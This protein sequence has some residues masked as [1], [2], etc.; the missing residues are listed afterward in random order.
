[1]GLHL[2]KV[3]IYGCKQGLFFEKFRKVPLGKFPPEENSP[4]NISD[5]FVKFRKFR[6]IPG[7]LFINFNHEKHDLPAV[8]KGL[9]TFISSC[10]E[11]FRKWSGSFSDN[12]LSHDQLVTTEFMSGTHLV[13]VQIYGCKQVFYF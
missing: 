9:Y 1:M 13:K 6:K 4:E 12:F 10:P 11:C 7:K 2:K 8:N 3:Q 5:N